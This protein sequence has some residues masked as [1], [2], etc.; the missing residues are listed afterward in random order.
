MQFHYFYWLHI[1]EVYLVMSRFCRHFGSWP[2]E[3]HHGVFDGSRARVK[4]ML[5]IAYL[6][7]IITVASGDIKEGLFGKNG[8]A[9]FVLEYQHLVVRACAAELSRRQVL[10]ANRFWQFCSR[11]GHLGAAAWAYC[12]YHQKENYTAHPQGL[13][14]GKRFWVFEMLLAMLSNTLSFIRVGALRWLTLDCL[15]Y[16]KPGHNGGRRFRWCVIVPGIIGNA[17]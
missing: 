17:A 14:C 12:Q 2:L 1:P 15:W 3:K 6:Y 16:L 7:S 11:F 4:A 8:I 10:F 9:G 5:F 13:L